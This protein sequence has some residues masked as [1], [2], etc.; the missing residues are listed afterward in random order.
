MEAGTAQRQRHLLRAPSSGG[1]D[2][3]R[4]AA[5]ESAREYQFQFQWPPLPPRYSHSAYAYS[6]HSVHVVGTVAKPKPS[7]PK[8]PTSMRRFSGLRSRHTMKPGKVLEAASRA[9]GTNSSSSREGW[10]TGGGMADGAQGP[11]SSSSGCC[12]GVALEVVALELVALELITLEFAGQ[13]AG[14][15]APLHH[16]AMLRV[17]VRAEREG[18]QLELF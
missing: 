11:G 12:G 2:R 17:D 5:M 14:E 4:V 16:L 7:K 6:Q 8:S 13:L 10:Q 18:R 1:A 9:L 3:G 15:I